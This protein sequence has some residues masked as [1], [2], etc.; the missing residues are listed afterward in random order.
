MR[1]L[2]ISKAFVWTV[3]TLLAVFAAGVC[4]PLF[5][6]VT[7]KCHGN[8]VSQ[9]YAVGLALW[10]YA[11]DNH[12]VMPK[13]LDSLFPDY[14][15]DKNLLDQVELLTPGGDLSELPA[16]TIIARREYHSENI[17]GVVHADLSAEASQVRS[18]KSKQ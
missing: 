8:H 11:D 7:V 13:T 4:L 18:L 17:V 5:S 6:T 1:A 10:L 14:V 15:A 3:I 12:G 16:K 9:V 2:S